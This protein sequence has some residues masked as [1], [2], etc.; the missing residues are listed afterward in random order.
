MNI[1]KKKFELTIQVDLDELDSDLLES[2]QDS[3]LSNK[4]M[5]NSETHYITPTN[6]EMTDSLKSEVKSWLE[7]LS[8]EVEIKENDRSKEIQEDPLKDILWDYIS[9]KDIPEIN[10]RLKEW[11]KE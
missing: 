11:R 6:E 2:H 4:D 7:A 5:P 8:L 3:W 9:E 10:R 1:Y